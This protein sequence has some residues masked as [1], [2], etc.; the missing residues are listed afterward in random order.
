[1]YKLKVLPIV[2]KIF[3]KLVKKDKKQLL[4][5]NKKITHLLQEPEIEKPQQ[6]N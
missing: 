2:D 5:I 3:K 1:M 6:N 4:A